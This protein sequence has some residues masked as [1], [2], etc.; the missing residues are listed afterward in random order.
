MLRCNSQHPTRFKRSLISPLCRLLIFA[1]T[2]RRS[3]DRRRFDDLSILGAIAEKGVN[4]SSTPLAVRV[5]SAIYMV[6]S[7]K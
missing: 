3:A 2:P 1:V 5:I 7:G 4:T 6:L